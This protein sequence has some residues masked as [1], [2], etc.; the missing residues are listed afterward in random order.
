MRSV[1]IDLLYSKAEHLSRSGGAGEDT[2][3]TYN[4]TASKRLGIRPASV[5]QAYEQF[6]A[7]GGVHI[8]IRQFPH[9]WDQQI[10][11]LLDDT[12]TGKDGN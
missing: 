7:R 12:E 2:P 1:T 6:D 11:L 3:V 8:V 10:P 9:R 5:R 4:K